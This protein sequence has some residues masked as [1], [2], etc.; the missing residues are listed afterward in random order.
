[1]A[2]A[3]T[4]PVLSLPIGMG[5]PIHRLSPGKIN[6]R[7]T[8]LPG[9]QKDGTSYEAKL[10][11]FY[12]HQ[13]ELFRPGILALYPKD[14]LLLRLCGSAMMDRSTASTIAFYHRERGDWADCAPFFPPEV[15]PPT[16]PSWIAAGETGTDFSRACGLPDHIPIFPGGI[17]SFCEAVGAGGIRPGI[18]VDGSG[19]STCLTACLKQDGVH[20]EH[21]LPGLALET[22]MLS[23]TGASYRW[24]CSLFPALDLDQIQTRIDPARPINLIYLP[25]LSGERSPIYDDRATGVFLGL[26]PDTGPQAL[27]QA[28]MQG[29]AFAVTQ[30]LDLMAESVEKVRAVGGANRST[31]WLQIKANASGLCFE[32]MEET[33]AAAFGCALLAGYGSGAYSLSE[34]EDLLQVRQGFQP[35]TAYRAEYRALYQIYQTLYPKLEDSYRAMYQL[36]AR[37][38]ADRGTDAL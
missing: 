30:N 13:P 4:D 15:M 11:W 23:N 6:V 33:D 5:R 9:F 10:C 29:V 7:W 32:Q 38:D 19:T 1:M 14:Y 22:P 37:L 3:V 27:L 2:C 24:L 25:Y 21:V 17:D 35:H 26:R 36:R 8:R 20:A 16:A 34:L 28:M 31:L 12:R 18:V